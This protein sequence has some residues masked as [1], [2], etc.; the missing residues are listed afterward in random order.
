MDVFTSH[1]TPNYIVIDRRLMKCMGALRAPV[2]VVLVLYIPNW[3]ALCFFWENQKMSHFLFCLALNLIPNFPIILYMPV[4]TLNIDIFYQAF[5]NFFSVMYTLQYYLQSVWNHS[6]W[7]GEPYYNIT[8][9]ILKTEL[10]WL[11]LS[12]LLLGEFHVSCFIFFH[13]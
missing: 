10:L 1:Q 5:G 12:D 6:W 8:F 11:V 4:S 3:C 7:L 9:F 13:T 2:S